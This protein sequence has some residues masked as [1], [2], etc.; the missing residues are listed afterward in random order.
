MVLRVRNAGTEIYMYTEGLIN[1]FIENLYSVILH[2]KTSF[3]YLVSETSPHLQ[4]KSADSQQQGGALVIKFLIPLLCT[5]V[6]Y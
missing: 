5:S 4:F 3:S 2:F 6:P 1:R